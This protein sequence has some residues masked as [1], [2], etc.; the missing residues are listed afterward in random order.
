[1]GFFRKIKVWHMLCDPLMGHNPP[2][3]NRWP[4]VTLTIWTTN[5]HKRCKFDIHLRIQTRKVVLN[6]PNRENKY[7]WPFSCC[8]TVTT[9]KIGKKIQF[10]EK[11]TGG[12]RTRKTACSP[13]RRSRSRGPGRSRRARRSPGSTPTAVSQRSVGRPA[14]RPAS[15]GT[16]SPSRAGPSRWS[17]AW[18]A[19]RAFVTRQGQCHFMRLW[20]M[21]TQR[22]DVTRD[23]RI[24][25]ILADIAI[26]KLL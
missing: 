15:R 26:N 7:R 25:K 18:E 13:R 22:W 24:W 20:T 10:F 16:T 14:P 6:H 2:V 11:P 19:R 17:P 5:R 4:T 9:N 1:M 23:A 8:E 21:W 3:E 12:P